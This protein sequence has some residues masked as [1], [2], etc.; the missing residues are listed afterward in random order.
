MNAIAAMC[1]LN[2]DSGDYWY[3]CFQPKGFEDNTDGV[4]GTTEIADRD[5]CDMIKEGA[6][7]DFDGEQY[8][9]T[10]SGDAYS[11]YINTQTGEAKNIHK[12]SI[13]AIE[14]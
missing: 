10:T 8:T 6:V 12:G 7:I 13:G 9:I 3:V 1:K 4:I 5:D 11:V 2:N 14:K